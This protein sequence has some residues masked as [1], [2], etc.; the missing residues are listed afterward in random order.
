[1]ARRR[2][3]G[4]G[5]TVGRLA[6]LFVAASITVAVFG[7]A[8]RDPGGFLDTLAARSK[9]LEAQVHRWVAAVGL[10]ET[11][12]PPR[13]VSPTAGPTRAAVSGRR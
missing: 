12:A 11:G 5:G 9:T 1:M 7:G 3:G 13:F 6:W 10:S 4:S 8:V 2:M